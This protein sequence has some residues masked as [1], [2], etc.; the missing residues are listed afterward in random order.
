[1]YYF[2]HSCNALTPDILK[3]KKRKNYSKWNIHTKLE[4]KILSFFFFD[5]II[6]VLFMLSGN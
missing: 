1:M 6:K 2:S 5:V 3:N 4:N